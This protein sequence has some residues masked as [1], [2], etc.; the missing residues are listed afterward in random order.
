M[1]GTTYNMTP[2]L[3][4]VPL[5][6]GSVVASPDDHPGDTGGGLLGF[7]TPLQGFTLVANQQVGI[8]ISH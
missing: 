7:T 3:G 2:M 6:T 8:V 5:E 4:G 1:P